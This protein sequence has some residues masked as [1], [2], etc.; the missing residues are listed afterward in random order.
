MSVR[1]RAA[2]CVRISEDWAVAATGYT[3]QTNLPQ[4]QGTLSIIS[5]ALQ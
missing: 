1:V 3:L 5:K 2:L 4:F